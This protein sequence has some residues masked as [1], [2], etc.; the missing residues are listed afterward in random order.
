[1]LAIKIG[2]KVKNSFI[3]AILLFLRYISCTPAKPIKLQNNIAANFE[4]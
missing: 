2:D 1:M 3:K 4:N